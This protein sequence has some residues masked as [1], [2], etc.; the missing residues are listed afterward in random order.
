MTRVKT[1]DNNNL[2]SVG[3]EDPNIGERKEI[4]NQTTP[5]QRKSVCQ[6]DRT[7]TGKDDKLKFT[8][9]IKIAPVHK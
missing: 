2:F 1:E 9:Y 8:I 7:M 4:N 5:V 3:G 6:K